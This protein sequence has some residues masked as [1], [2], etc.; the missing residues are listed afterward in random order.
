MKP[1]INTEKHIVQVSLG[2]VASGA[3][4]NYV[5]ATAV[6]VPTSA[7]GDIREGCIIKA[8]WL[9]MWISSDD[10]GQGTAIVTVEKVDGATATLMTTAES[11]ALGSYDN[12]KNVLHTQMGLVPS[13][14][15]YPM[16]SLKGWFKIPKGKQ[17]FGLGERLVV[18][19][20]G[21]SNGLNVCGT[22]I[23]KEQY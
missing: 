10:A 9:E 6:A 2:T 19:I 11:A 14:V 13:N 15:D 22:G 12:K 17:R 7:L 4:T 21:Q 23:Y 1:V 18:N 5:F 3:I 20:H 16:A 8:I